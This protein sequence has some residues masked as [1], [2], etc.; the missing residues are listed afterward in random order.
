M[1][2]FAYESAS[3][4]QARAGADRAPDD[5][6]ARLVEAGERPAERRRAGQHRVRR[7]A[8]VLEHELGGDGRAERDLLVDL[9]RGEPG[10]PLL[11]QEAADLAVLGARP[12]DRDVR[13]RA[14]RDPHLGAVQDPVRSRRAARA[15]ASRPGRSPASGSVRPKQPITS[16]RC[17]GGSQCSFCS[18]DP[19]RQIANI[20]SDPWTETALRTPAS[21]ASSSRQVRP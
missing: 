16:P 15:F 17:I 8:D 14:V 4:K 10:H 9:G 13:D 6:V 12:D 20:A 11:D 21:P 3:S 18:S 1:R 2:S 7:D 19:Q 5:P